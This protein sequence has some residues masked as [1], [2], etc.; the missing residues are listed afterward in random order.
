[1]PPRVVADEADLEIADRGVRRRFAGEPLADGNVGALAGVR[2]RR[3]LQPRGARHRHGRHQQDDRA[4]RPRDQRAR[5]RR[6]DARAAEPAPRGVD[7]AREAVARPGRRRARAAPAAA[8]A[9]QWKNGSRIWRYAT[10]AITGQRREQEPAA[11]E[12]QQR[13][14]GGGD[15]EERREA[16]LRPR[17]KPGR[18][19]RGER[20]QPEEH[21]GAERAPEPADPL[22]LLGRQ[23]S[24][25]GE[26]TTIHSAPN[27]A[28][29]T[30]ADTASRTSGTRRSR[31]TC[32]PRRRRA[33]AGR[34]A[35]ASWPPRRRPSPGPADRGRTAWP[36][37]TRAPP[38][39]PSRR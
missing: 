17:R 11:A 39:A 5:A 4:D 33:P 25:S 27:H 21:V 38:A 12:W 16:R 13:E 30:A 37:T 31:Q 10:I 24:G 6:L 34:R 8:P 1:M 15:G 14:A 20:Q 29:S 2:T 19:M 18:R 36:P 28:A 32:A 3:A 23:V 9:Y 22:R 35:S 7:R 26:P